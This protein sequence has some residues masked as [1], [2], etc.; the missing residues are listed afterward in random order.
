MA[1]SCFNLGVFML[2]VNDFHF[3]FTVGQSKEPRSLSL[4]ANVTSGC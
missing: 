2:L 3:V 4:S 1:L